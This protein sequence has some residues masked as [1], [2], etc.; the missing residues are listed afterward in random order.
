[1]GD[2][3]GFET[4]ELVGLYLLKELEN[5]KINMGLYR[6]DMLGVSDKHFKFHMSHQTEDKE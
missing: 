1:M 6:D 4:C 2:Y 3:N 5:L